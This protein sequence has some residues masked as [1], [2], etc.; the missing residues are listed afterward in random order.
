M[1]QNY[2]NSSK[3]RSARTY[4]WTHRD[5]IL[6]KSKARYAK[7]AEH[8][9]AVREQAAMWRQ[10]HLSYARKLDNAL[11]MARYWAKKGDAEKAQQ[12]RIQAKLIKMTLPNR[13]R[14]VA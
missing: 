14:P 7:D 4:Y 1:I 11:H 8:A 5:Q 9:Q 13:R 2:C 12:C 10:A 6:A 3:N